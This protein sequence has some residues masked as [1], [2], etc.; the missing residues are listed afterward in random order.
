M[1]ACMHVEI[2]DNYPELR[3]KGGND[4]VGE[5]VSSVSPRISINR[6]KVVVDIVI[7]SHANYIACFTEE[8]VSRFR[9]YLHPYHF[10]CSLKQLNL[11]GQ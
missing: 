6:Q 3:I 5:G 1:H 4:V 7:A 10:L 11:F 8:L 2:I 9:T